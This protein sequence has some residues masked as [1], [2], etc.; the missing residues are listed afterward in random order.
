MNHYQAVIIGSGQGGTP[1]AKKL[2]QAGWQT[3]LIEKNV[4][5]GTCVNTGCTPTKTLIASAKVAH[6]AA[7]AG[8]WGVEVK[9]YRVNF[10]AVINRKNQVVDK[11]RNGSRKGLESTDNLT[12]IFGEASFSGLKELRVNLTEGGS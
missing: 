1:L 8:K 7:Q 10:P 2:A 5:G 9:D 11:F 12:L 3:A 4:I 6:T